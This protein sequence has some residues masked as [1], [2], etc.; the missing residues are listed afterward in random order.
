MKVLEEIREIF[1]LILDHSEDVSR[2]RF[3]ARMKNGAAFRYQFDRQ[4]WEKEQQKDKV[5]KRE[6]NQLINAILDVVGIA[7]GISILVILVVFAGIKAGP[8]EVATYS[9]SGA[10]LIIYFLFSAI[11]NF[12]P[13]SHTARDFFFRFRGILLF[14]TMAGFY[15]PLF[16]LYT[17]STAG[18]TFVGIMLLCSLIGLYMFGINTK[19]ARKLAGAAGILLAWTPIAALPFMMPGLGIFRSVL[20]GLIV[21]LLTFWTVAAMREDP[22]G[23][24]ETPATNLFLL[25]ASLSIFWLHI[26]WLSP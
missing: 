12:L 19:G 3:E 23:Q 7:A 16:L 4:K 25:F 9:I 8:T 11:F 26:L 10:L 13:P 15:L 21:L 22:Q 18:A 24:K 6:S 14:L 20:V 17:G 2:I 1:N 5:P